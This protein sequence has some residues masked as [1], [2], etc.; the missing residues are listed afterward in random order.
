MPSTPPSRLLLAAAVSG[1][2]AGLALDVL[3]FLVARYG[4]QA[5]SWSFRGNGALVVPLG[6]GPAILA[7]AYTAMVLHARGVPD[8]LRIGLSAG[9]VGALLIVASSAAV[10][11]LDRGGE[12]ISQVLILVTWLWTLA[13]PL[14]AALVPTHTSGRWTGSIAHVASAQL[15]TVAMIG[16]FYGAGQ[17]LPPSS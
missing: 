7:A 10:I 2:V 1:L 5:G 15:F 13:A 6:L 9:A 17:I 12:S 8:W 11:V 3:A 14:F 16:A 4:P